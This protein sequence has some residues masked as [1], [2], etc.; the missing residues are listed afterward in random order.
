MGKHSN[1]ILLNENNKIID[2]LRH[3]DVSS[4]SLRDI[5]P[6]REYVL[7]SND[8]KKDFYNTSEEDL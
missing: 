4:G 6:A 5:L 1:I 2:S 7:P 3:L 8:N